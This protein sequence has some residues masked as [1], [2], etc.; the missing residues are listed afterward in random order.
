M[1]VFITNKLQIHLSAYNTKTIMTGCVCM[2]AML[3]MHVSGGAR[4]CAWGGYSSLP[5]VFT[6]HFP[7]LPG[8]RVSH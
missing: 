1:A 3:H 6:Y 2:R 5:A 7:L 4:V 8:E